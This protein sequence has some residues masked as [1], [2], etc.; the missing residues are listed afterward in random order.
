MNVR[1]KL[2]P[3][4]QLTIE[5]FLAFT[6][7]RPQEERWELIE[8]VAVMNPSPV[9]HHQVV[10]TNIATYLMAHKQRTGASWLPLLGVGTRVPVSPHSLPQP[11]LF[12]KEGA[13]TDRPV[14]D[15][16]LVLFEVLSRSNTRGD[17]AWRR[18]VYASVP[19]C[20]HYVTVSLKATVVEA[21]DRDS[22]W[23]RRT[24]TG[25]AEALALPALGLSIPLADIY[26]WTPLGAP[27]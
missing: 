16:A 7:T 2:T 20:R 10:V 17:Q 27:I 12:V 3:E 26:R 11:D 25:L 1:P 6:E 4:Q 9:E 8:G 18:K 24:F 22:A 23:K 13:A 15:D 19:N 5:E 14:T 21:Y